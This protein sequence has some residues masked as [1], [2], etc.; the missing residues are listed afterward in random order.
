[1]TTSDLER[2]LVAVLHHH[3]EEAMNATDTQ[4]QLDRLRAR[5]HL[6]HAA[7]PGRWVMAG[8]AAAAV[9]AALVVW[10]GLRS[11]DDETAPASDPSSSAVKVANAFVQA[12]GAF[13]REAAA[14]QLA[15]D[16]DLAIWTDA[17]GTDQWR[18]GN[19][20]LQAIGSQLILRS[21]TPTG[22]TSAGTTVTC[23]YDFH[24][25]NSDELRRGPFSGDTFEF[26]IR[27][28]KITSAHTVFNYNTN[29]FS[30]T[31]W[32]PF[33]AWVAKNHPRDAAI[34]YSDWP[35]TS[36][37]ALTDESISL[38]QQHTENY[39]AVMRARP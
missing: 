33:A 16:A 1:M 25:L 21:C 3:A 22:T 32:E 37:E 29:G 5:T 18:Q 30:D 9:V 7:S 38:W 10:S 2:R 11:G 28:N 4:E 24:A 14:A 13:D 31:M 6:D 23:A 17:T 8:I 27:D 39:L 15:P 20:F 26:V 19:R 34:M 36:R 35:G 12:W